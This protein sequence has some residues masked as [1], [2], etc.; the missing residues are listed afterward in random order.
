MTRP[1]HA[2]PACRICG[3]DHWPTPPRESR[4]SLLLGIVGVVL[5]AFAALWLWPVLS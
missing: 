2:R 3:A 1:P 5:F 4:A